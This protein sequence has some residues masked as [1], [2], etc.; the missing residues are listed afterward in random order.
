M[1]GKW[2]YRWSALMG[3][4]TG[5]SR[6]SVTDWVMDALKGEGWEISMVCSR[7]QRCSDF[8]MADV[9]DS[10]KIPQSG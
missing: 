5:V 3:I 6:E 1:V 7:G 8:L 10:R 9:W 4:M 2:D